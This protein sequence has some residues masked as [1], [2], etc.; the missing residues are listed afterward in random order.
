MSAPQIAG[1]KQQFICAVG[2]MRQNIPHLSALTAEFNSILD[3]ATTSVGSLQK[4]KLQR[5]ALMSIGWSQKHR[6]LWNVSKK[7]FFK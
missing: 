4:K 1:D 6:A 2:W 7:L 3:V 5:V